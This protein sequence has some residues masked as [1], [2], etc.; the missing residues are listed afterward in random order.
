MLDKLNA[1]I[2]E[3]SAPISPAEVACGWGQESK[4]AIKSYFS[5]VRRCYAA[6]HPLPALGVIRGLD[7]W[8]ISS[9]YLCQ[10]C[11]H[12]TL[13]LREESAN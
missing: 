3:L 11:I 8:G 7:A 12:V 4:Q 6:E 9:G 5:E 13:K 2:A 1:L 10:Q